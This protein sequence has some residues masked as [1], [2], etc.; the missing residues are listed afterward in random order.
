MSSGGVTTRNNF[1]VL[2]SS[3]IFHNFIDKKM[4]ETLA[5][6]ITLRGKSFPYMLHIWCNLSTTIY[7]SYMV[8]SNTKPEKLENT[9]YITRKYMLHIWCEKKT[10]Q[11]CVKTTLKQ[12]IWCV[13]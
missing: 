8:S 11:I 9:P 3:K 6:V 12:E 13:F 2:E 10:H 1:I 4:T 5:M 7:A